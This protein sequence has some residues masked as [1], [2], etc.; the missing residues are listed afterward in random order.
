M[1]CLSSYSTISYVKT[2]INLS[3]KIEHINVTLNS[4]TIN[5]M[6]EAKVLKFQIIKLRSK[7]K[8]KK[9]QN[10]SHISSKGLIVSDHYKIKVIIETV[11]T[12]GEKG[13][14]RSSK[15]DELQKDIWVSR[16]M[17]QW[18]NIAQ[19]FTFLFS[20]SEVFMY[21]TRYLY[22]IFQLF[23]SFRSSE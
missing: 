2:E 4:T 20:V 8:K 23:G 22:L 10:C 9:C 11:Q 7:Y 19:V 6:P 1:F 13:K 17:Y 12:Q 15:N 21:C 16:D 3:E 18:S 14:S 5:E